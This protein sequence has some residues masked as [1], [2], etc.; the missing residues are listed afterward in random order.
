MKIV[1]KMKKLFIIL[2]CIP[3]LVFSSDEKR[4]ALVIG[5]SD[6]DQAPLNNPV[7]DA[8]LM[9]KTLEAL[10][11]D[12]IL[13]TNITSSVGFVKK[14]L[15]FGKKRPD[16]DVGFVYYAGHAV[17]MGSLN[18]MIPTK[19]EACDN[20]KKQ[21]ENEDDIFA[22]AV[23][24]QQI[25]RHLS[26]I[27]GTLNILVLDAC[28]NMP[29]G[30]KT[31]SFKGSGSGLAKIDPPTGS[32]IAFST[33]AGETAADGKGKNSIYCS[34]LSKHMLKEN[35]SL[36]ELF[37]NV[38]TEV[39]SLTNGKQRPD[40]YNART[41]DVYYLVKSNFEKSFSKIEELITQKKYLD[42]TQ[43]TR[44]VLTL[45]P[46]NIRAYLLEGKAYHKWK[47]YDKALISYD[48]IINLD[49]KNI[50]AYLERAKV[51]E[52]LEDYSKSI[53]DINKVIS[54]DSLSADAFNR[55]GIVYAYY[56]DSL[57]K[58][59]DDFNKSLS[60]DSTYSK[61]YNGLAYVYSELTDIEEA[62]INYDIAISLAT[63]K[64]N[65]GYS[66]L[67]IF[68]ENRAHHFML[69]QEYN[70]ALKD[71][72]TSISIDSSYI[73]SY[74][75]RGDLYYLYLD[76][77]EKALKDFNTAINI[78]EDNDHLPY[79]YRAYYYEHI[80]DY[81]QELLEWSRLIDLD[82]KS[83]FFYESRGI[84][85]SNLKN[86]DLAIVD[87][88]KGI[89]LS[90]TTYQKTYLI[91]L[92]A[93]ANTDLGEFQLA[94][95][96]YALAFELDSLE[97]LYLSNKGLNYYQN[98]N[99][100]EN[101][102][103]YFNDAITLVKEND[104]NKIDYSYDLAYYYSNR[105]YCY[106]YFDEYEN[107]I[108]DFKL[109]L[110]LDSIDHNTLLSIADCYSNTGK[111]DLA[112]EYYQ[113]AFERSNDLY[114][115][116]RVINNKAIVYGE[117]GEYQLENN[118]F[119]LAF[120]LDSLEPLYLSN[121]AKSYS[122]DLN[123]N[124]NALIYYNAA[125]TLA[126]END[127]NKIDYSH[128]LAYY[129]YSRGLFF[130][131]IYD[132]ENAI[133]DF[134][135]AIELQNSEKD[136]MKYWLFLRRG[137]CY[138]DLNKYDLA[139]ADYEKVLDLA[140]TNVKKADCYHRIADSYRDL[141]KY[142][143]ALDC[144]LKALE[145][146]T[147]AYYYHINL[148]IIYYQYLND[149]KKALSSFNK[150]ISLD[151]VNAVNYN[152]RADYF[153]FINDYENALLDH[154]KSIELDSAYFYYYYERAD[155]HSQMGNQDLALADLNKAEKY[156]S[157]S[158]Y[159]EHYAKLGRVYQS[160]KDFDKAFINFQKS[161]DL[162]TTNRSPLYYRAK[163]YEEI[164]EFE[165]QRK[166]LLST[167]ALDPEDPEGYYFLALSYYQN[168]NIFKAINYISKSI[169]KFSAGGGYII[170]GDKL[171]EE[172]GLSEL[173]LKRA[174]IYDKADATDMAC[175]SYKLACDLGECELFNTNCK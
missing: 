12:V 80:G 51:Y 14:I 112:I 152:Y 113:K 31:R 108:I 37:M 107:A 161:I 154:N 151:T 82:P 149:N 65:S 47:K 72:T 81:E 122:Q 35:T 49:A 5:N 96:A 171:G 55:R 4:L 106:E 147:S 99:D 118:E 73:K 141:K 125:I 119:A 84:A 17:Q 85:Y 137:Q 109:S 129:L 139:I 46:V 58:G 50:T 16:Y 2:F 124:E 19:C 70:K 28:R 167:I 156:I 173:Y 105:G 130:K 29:L 64:K 21:F 24:V 79:L 115:K 88:N 57:Q 77:Y 133:N 22:H 111:F 91:N 59:L 110:S 13:D 123:D 166:D 120:E 102:L 162:D 76:D 7:N 148:A 93:I 34:S 68:Y 3:L 83:S 33:G 158:E 132:Y 52:D 30:E 39:L 140:T 11:F 69:N 74:L 61:A 163:L 121:R 87:F 27:S 9:A 168:N 134:S 71:Y 1:S 94:N 18:Y 150:A 10:D 44:E 89:D 117:L 128:N 136:K 90:E 114:Q 75:K 6:Y 20:E 157:E 142:K 95:D 174:D 170:S 144:F 160:L 42:A 101:A 8:L 135:T 169:E 36:N 67:H 26:K 15:E 54:F 103:I 78:N 143:L 86:Y 126:K 63:D 172:I 100:Y 98:L 127:V 25:M 104:V 153:Y 40:E 41:G 159:S 56:L 138:Y 131:N 155:I 145:L 53:N 43:K 66:S 38:R 165:N 60:I 62:T 45:D 116:T 92:I 146:D 48:N 23:G 32:L 175:E 97:P 164:G